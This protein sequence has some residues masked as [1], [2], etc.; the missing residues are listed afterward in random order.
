MRWSD[1]PT[2]KKYKALCG[3]RRAPRYRSLPQ[4][5]DGNYLKMCKSWNRPL[6]TE[7]NRCNFPHPIKDQLDCGCCWAFST[8][9]VLEA[10]I[11]Q[12]YGKRTE[13]S[14]QQLVDCDFYND[15]CDGG[16]P[17]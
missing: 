1:W 3:T 8:I 11:F 15:A 17:S 6:P 7:L 9:Q 13:L 4:A 10:L 14:V 5:N 2:E 12:C 16:W